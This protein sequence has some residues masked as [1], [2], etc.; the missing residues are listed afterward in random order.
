MIHVFAFL[1]LMPLNAEE[2]LARELRSVNRVVVQHV[3]RVVTLHQSP[4]LQK[5]QVRK[6]RHVEIEGEPPYKIWFGN[7]GPFGLWMRINLGDLT[8]RDGLAIELNEEFTN[9]IFA[10][11]F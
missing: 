4:I 1:I 10:L 6:I 2:Q 3:E 7:Y 9:E 5:L 8:T 11:F